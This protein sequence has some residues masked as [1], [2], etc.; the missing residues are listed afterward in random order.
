VRVL[1]TGSAGFVGQHLVKALIVEPGCVIIRYDRYHGDDV[2]DYEHL[3]TAVQHAEPDLIFH[4]AAMT[5][6]RE[7]VTDPHRCMEV[8]LLGTLNLLD[9]VRNSGSHARVLLAGT[10]EEYGYAGRDGEVLTEKSPC[11]PANPYAVSKLAAGQLGLDYA[12]RYGIPV[13]VTRAFNHTGPGRQAANAES[14]FARKIA[15]AEKGPD[16]V[17]EHGDLSA[18]RNFSDVRDVVRAYRLAITQEP[19]YYNVCSSRNV[20][21]REV[22]DILL[23]QAKVPVQLKR[24]PYLG[25]KPEGGF[26]R[27]SHAKLTGATGWKPEIPLEETLK[28]LLAYWR[29]R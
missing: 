11:R 21:M 2:R 25:G 8:N 3:R 29:R 24:S 13:V 22:M 7:S 27:P 9:A 26:P 14:A 1:I 4:L 15:L 18:T 17:V 6:P 10:S 19:G 23:A 28:D 16:V 5:W 20:T 12:S